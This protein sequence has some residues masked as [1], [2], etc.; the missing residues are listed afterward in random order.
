MCIRHASVTMAL[1]QSTLRAKMWAS[2][3][4]SDLYP[5]CLLKDLHN[6]MQ[7]SLGHWGDVQKACVSHAGSWSRSHLE[8]NLCVL[9]FRFPSRSPT[10]LYGF[11]WNKAAMFRLCKTICRSQS[12]FNVNEPPFSWLLHIFYTLWWVFMNI[13]YIEYVKVTNTVS[14]RHRAITLAQR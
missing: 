5:L 8:V 1:G 2:T 10:T 4:I 7:E 13:V 9:H 12:C 11:S 3:F 6:T 14:R